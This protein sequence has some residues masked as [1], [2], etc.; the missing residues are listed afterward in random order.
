MTFNYYDNKPHHL[1]GIWDR[2]ANAEIFADGKSLGTLDISS[3]SAVDVQTS[4]STCIACR[5]DVSAFFNGQIFYVFIW[6]RILFASEVRQLYWNPYAMFEYPNAF[7]SFP[8][9]TI[10]DLFQPQIQTMKQNYRINLLKQKNII[11][12]EKQENQ[13]KWLQ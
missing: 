7:S 11:N 12:S 4:V 5:D 1:V 6:N 3:K 9:L 8:L 10:L 2:S 13:I